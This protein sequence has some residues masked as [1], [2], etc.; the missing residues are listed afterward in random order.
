MRLRENFRLYRELVAAHGGSLAEK[1]NLVQY[2]DRY[3]YI[4][5]VECLPDEIGRAHV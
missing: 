2:N 1:P 3:V 5:C 4:K